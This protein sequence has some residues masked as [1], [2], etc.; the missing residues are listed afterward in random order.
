MM[1]PHPDVRTTIDSTYSTRRMFRRAT[2]HGAAF[3]RCPTYLTYVLRLAVLKSTVVP[4]VRP[5]LLRAQCR[6]VRLA[7]SSVQVRAPQTTNLDFLY[8]DSSD[9][10]Y[11]ATFSPPAVRVFDSSDL[12]SID[13]IPAPGPLQSQG[14]WQVGQMA[15]TGGTTLW[16]A[17]HYSG[18]VWK[19]N[20]TTGAVIGNLSSA[21]VTRP[22]SLLVRATNSEIVL[23]DLDSGRLVAFSADLRVRG[24]WTSPVASLRGR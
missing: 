2:A 14:H 10:L 24:V 22:W 11:M 3:H 12:S 18:V 5:P 13:S 23:G 17:G 1:I 20:L 16:A 15:I 6:S 19:F 21:L 9:R 4:V 7:P 8:D